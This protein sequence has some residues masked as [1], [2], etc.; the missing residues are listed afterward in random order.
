MAPASI[1]QQF[2]FSHFE[3]FELRYNAD[4]VSEFQRLATHRRWKESSKTYR[5]HHRACFEPPPSFIT[6]PP[7]TAPISFNSFFNVVG[8]NYEPTATVEANFERLA[9]NQ[10]WKQ[11]T[12]E[13]RFFRE[14]AY[15]SE[16]NEHF[17]DNKLAA[18][19]E[20]CGELGVTI[21]P[22][23]ITQCKK[24]IQT[25]RVNI[26]N[27]L[28][29]R[30]NPSAVPLLRFNNYKAFR[31]YTKKHIYPKACAKKNEFLKTLLRRI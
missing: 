9:K 16:F 24:T 27:L 3:D 25:M 29:H 11:H 7:P 6:V 22:S 1:H 23:S 28:E 14:Q 2:W 31:K 4:V 15:D 26:I 18:W 10:G 8:F 12:D 19:Q 30:R 20:F 21:I 5:K 13:Y 17:G